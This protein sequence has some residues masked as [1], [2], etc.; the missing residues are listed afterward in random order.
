MHET[1]SGIFLIKTFRIASFSCTIYNFVKQGTG[2]LQIL[3]IYL[4]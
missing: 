2:A 4:I 3:L 1:G